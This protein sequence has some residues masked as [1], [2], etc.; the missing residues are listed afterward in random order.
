MDFSRPALA[1]APGLPRRVLDVLVTAEGP[2]S[3]RE[4]ARRAGVSANGATTVLR[5]LAADGPVWEARL[6]HA[7]LYVLDPE[8]LVTPILRQLTGVVDELVRRIGE[9]AQCWA[10][11]PTWVGL[12]D[13]ASSPDP[14]T[15]TLVV[16]RPGRV[17]AADP[18]WSAQLAD[19][20]DRVA[21]WAR[22]TV[23]CHELD[24]G[25]VRVPDDLETG[26]VLTA[27]GQPSAS[28]RAYAKP[29]AEEGAPAMVEPARLQAVPWADTPGT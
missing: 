21:R 15:M 22:S 18:R 27:V 1:V 3:A 2:L 8:H 29:S 4:I 6:A 9:Q 23:A 28:H 13:P 24:E 7:G 16:A 5:G 14:R 25:D 17:D 11:A 12:V 26:S 19:L 10:L 20:A